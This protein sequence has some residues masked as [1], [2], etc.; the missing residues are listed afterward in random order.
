MYYGHESSKT[1]KFGAVEKRGRGFSVHVYSLSNGQWL[2]RSKPVP[3][4][5]VGRMLDRVT[6]RLPWYYDAEFIRTVKE[7]NAFTPVVESIRKKCQ[8]NPN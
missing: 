3:F 6:D 5:E 7:L 1:L 4:S 8:Y 2:H